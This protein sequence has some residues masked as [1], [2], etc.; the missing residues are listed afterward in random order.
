MNQQKDNAYLWDRSGPPDSE[1]QQLEGLLG[2]YR[3]GA[4]RRRRFM[5]LAAAALL[6]AA[7]GVALWRPTEA[8]DGAPS[9]EVEWLAGAGGGRLAVGD[10]LETD[11][12]SRARI[13]VAD[14]GRVDLD[15]RSRVRLVGTGQQEHRLELERGKLHAWV[16]APPRL[17]VVDTPAATAVDL[18]CAYILEVDERGDG[19]LIVTTGYVELQDGGGIA[20]LVPG[21]AACSMRKGR[22]PGV[23]YRQHAPEALR[24]VDAGNARAVSAALEAARERDTLTLWHLLLRVD[25]PTRTAVYDRMAALAPPPNGVT[26]EEVLALDAAALQRWRATLSSHW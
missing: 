25:E 13:T 14:I 11:D 6:L 1:V 2:R 23:P 22:G 20:S 18:G 9:W 17:F 10:W 3:F 5:F 12:A 19:L 26:R 24:D 4:R 16:V 8:P 15:P 7:A 21:G